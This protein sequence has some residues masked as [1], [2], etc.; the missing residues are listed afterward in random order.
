MQHHRWIELFN[1]YDCEIC[2]HRGTEN[3]VADALT[4]K[5]RV[6]P[7]RVR[8]MSMTLQSSIKDK[9]QAAQKEAKCKTFD[10]GE[11]QEFAFQ[12]LKDKLCNAPVLALLDG[13]KDFMIYCDASEL[14]LG[15]TE[16][17]M[18]HHRWIELFNDYDC[19]ICYHRGTENVVADALTM[20]K[21]VKPKRV[22]AMSMTLHSSIKDKI[23][24]AQKEAVDESAGLQ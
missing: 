17:N 11:E 23:Q 16:L 21:R 2:Y 20:K 14:G 1:D 5:K 4:M 10:W 3:V 13:P 7:K 8:A 22:R 18:Q 19:E 12:T 9:I 15:C 6:N 24:A